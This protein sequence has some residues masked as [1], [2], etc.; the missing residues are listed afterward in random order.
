MVGYVSK[1]GLGKPDAHGIYFLK[2]L[3]PRS[4]ST[5]ALHGLELVPLNVR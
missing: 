4:L 5:D 1:N 2:K 3:D